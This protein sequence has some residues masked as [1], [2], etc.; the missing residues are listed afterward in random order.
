MGKLNVQDR[1]VV[2]PGEILAE[3]MDYLPAGDVIREGDNLISIKMGLVNINNRLIKVVPLS[4]NYI[5]KRGDLV[6]GKV[7]DIGLFGWRVNFGW[8]YEG[9]IS[10]R[11][12]GEFVDRNNDLTRYY[13]LGDY[14]ISRI[15]R[16]SGSKII[17]LSMKGP[18]LRKLGPGRLINVASAKVPRIIGKQGSMISMIKEATDCKLSVG[19]N[20]IVWISGTDPKKEDIAI[21]A[22][23]KIEDESHIQGLT[24][25]IKEFLEKKNT[26]WHTQKDQTEENLMN[27]EK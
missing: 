26:K 24:E 4:G 21:E 18:G 8:A 16:V 11:D 27:L 22:I 9:T 19:Q 10:I 3:G 6:I 13:D 15:T 17:D 12:V 2:V 7:V 20:G 1:D 25:R 14:V 23:K 5:P